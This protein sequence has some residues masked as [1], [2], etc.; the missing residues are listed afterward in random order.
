MDIDI[1]ILDFEYVL[2]TCGDVYRCLFRIWWGGGKKDLYVLIPPSR[3]H[4]RL[5]RKNL[6]PINIVAR[7]AARDHKSNSK[8]SGWVRAGL[9]A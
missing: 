4:S 2:Y 7:A 8:P 9:Y 6:I 3:N 5:S 1:Y